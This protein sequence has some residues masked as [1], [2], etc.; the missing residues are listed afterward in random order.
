MADTLKKQNCGKC[1]KPINFTKQKYLYCDGEC[2]KA[3]HFPKCSDMS[4]ERYEEITDN[5]EIRWLC[6]LC[7]NKKIQRRS[8]ISDL[9]TNSAGSTTPTASTKTT[10]VLPTMSI[11]GKFELIYKE[12]LEIRKQKSQY[13]KTINDL[14]TVIHDY[15]AI[16]ENLIQENIQLKNDTQILHDKFEHLEYTKDMHEQATLNHNLIINGA[17][18][19]EEENTKQKV[20]NIATAL[21]VDINEIDITNAFRKTTA[22][23]NT[24][25]LPRTI[26]VTFKNKEK[27]D[28]FLKSKLAKKITWKSVNQHTKEN[29][30]IYFGEQLTGR[31]QYL[32]K[33]ARDLKRDSIIK[34]VWVK[35]GDIFIRHSEESRIIKIT[36]A[37]QIQRLR[38][39]HR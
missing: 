1:Y 6:D 26:V 35:D 2:K 13:E 29:R 39:E 17:P 5:P 15:K 36:N 34:F 9:N 10:S 12:L 28:T 38:D 7:R 4:G 31:K 11:E 8:M 33:M 16:V 37:T 3:W 22:G 18:E 24:S 25:G 32:S 27:R 30:P 21:Q 23:Q 19:E 20:I 14:A